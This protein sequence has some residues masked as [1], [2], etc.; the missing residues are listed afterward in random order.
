MVPKL[1]P[2]RP[3]VHGWTHPEL[4][5]V[6]SPVATDWALTQSV[7]TKASV[8]KETLPLLSVPLVHDVP[9]TPLAVEV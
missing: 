8:L 4:L 6:D 5:M 7:P 9:V 1:S 2:S 3:R